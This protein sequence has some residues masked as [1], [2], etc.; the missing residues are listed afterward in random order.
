MIQPQHHHGKSRLHRS[1]FVKLI[2]NDICLLIP[3]QLYYNTHAITVGFI[4]KIGDT[5]NDFVTHEV[6][7]F[8]KQVGL[9]DL[10]RNL[11]NNNCFFAT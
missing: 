11:C 3:F 7:D 9:V 5:F 4:A 8:L 2:E 1:V 10:K 6:S